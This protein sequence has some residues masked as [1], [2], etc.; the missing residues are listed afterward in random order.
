MREEYYDVV[1][2]GGGPAGLTA[3]IYT[4]RGKLST[5][6]L[7][8][9]TLGGNTAIAGLIDNYPGFPFGIEGTA[10]IEEFK[11]QAERFGAEIRYGRVTAVEDTGAGKRVAAGEQVYACR[12]L[13]I[14]TGAKRRQLNIPGEGE[15]LGRGVSY[16]ATCDGPFF[17]GATVA[18]VG[19]GDAAVKEALHLSHIAEKV[20][21]IH[22]REQ[23]TANRTSWEK[24]LAEPNG[25]IMRNK[26]VTEMSGDNLLHAV[27]LLDTKDGSR[28]TLALEGIFISVGLIAGEGFAGYPE[29][30][31]NGYIV[32]K[33]SVTTSLPGVFAAGDACS[34]PFR[35][36]ATAVGDGTMAAMAAA[37]Y[38]QE[39][40]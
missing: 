18:V 16:C 13:I 36:V 28:Q 1:I 15:Y 39:G 19:G 32:S 23:F 25:E 33:N 8:A 14:A 34:K 35:Q 5:L 26:V 9:E 12:A 22:R 40:R 31:E 37:T 27:E 24:L 11:R 30:D 4:A 38:L 17:T 20:Y 21:L 6:L 7:E 3:A 10:L 2:V 29:T